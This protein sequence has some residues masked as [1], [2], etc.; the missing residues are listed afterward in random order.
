MIVLPFTRTTFIPAD[1][2]TCWGFFSDPSNL[3]RI[4][5]PSMDFRITS[6]PCSQMYAGQII[7]YRVRPLAGIP[8]NWVTEITQV[9]EGSFFIDEQRIGP[10]RFWHHQHHFREVEGGTE[11]TDIV[12]YALP[13]D[14]FSRI[15]LPVVKRKLGSIFAFR[16]EV[17]RKLF[18]PASA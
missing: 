10:Y 8:V 14:P 6:D 11:M 17:I 16:E 15:L 18:H 2:N 7:T 4:T 5:P 1:R 9:R 3:Q 13:L 12:H